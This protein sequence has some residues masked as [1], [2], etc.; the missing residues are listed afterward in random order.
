MST[1][2]RSGGIGGAMAALAD[3]LQSLDEG[4]VADVDQLVDMLYLAWDDLDGSNAGAMAAHKLRRLERPEW[5]PLHLTFWVERHGGTVLGSTRA[6]LHH[7]AVNIDDGSAEVVGGSRRQLEEAAPRVDVKPLARDVAQ[8]IGDHETN[9]PRVRRRQDG[10]VKV[11]LSEIL[12]AAKKQT[13]EGRR[14]RFYDTLDALLGEA[15]Y[16]RAGAVY[17]RVGGDA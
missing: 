5:D 17:M 16:S 6:E 7:W 15:G 10:A 8:L 2:E 4:P 9:D 3:Y 12:P 13:Q 14:R 1:K 11:V